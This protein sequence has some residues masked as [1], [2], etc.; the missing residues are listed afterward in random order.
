MTLQDEINNLEHQLR[1]LKSQQARC[2]HEWGEPKYN[3][4]MVKRE[5]ALHGQYTTHGIHQY[6][7]TTFDNVEKPR[8][9]RVCKKCGIVQH[10]ENQRDIPQPKRQAPDFVTAG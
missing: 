2:A 9:T 5:R 4:Y 1:D 7:R 6:P 3:P 8:W 10:T